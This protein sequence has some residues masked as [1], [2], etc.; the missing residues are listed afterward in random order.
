MQSVGLSVVWKDH[1]SV[2]PAVWST[3]RWT[4]DVITIVPADGTVRSREWMFVQPTIGRSPVNHGELIVPFMRVPGPAG[5]V[6]P[7]GPVAPSAPS[8][9]VWPAGPGIANETTRAMAA[10]TTATAPSAAPIFPACAGAPIIGLGPGIA[11][12]GSG[13]AGAPPPSVGCMRDR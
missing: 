10:R 4:V 11:G 8:A 13:G 7:R 9:P 12:T 1:E 3:Q 2:T 6:G 5:P